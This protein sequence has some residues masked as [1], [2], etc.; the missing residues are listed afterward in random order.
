[1]SVDANGKLLVKDKAKT[2]AWLAEVSIQASDRFLPDFKIGSL[3]MLR[4][5]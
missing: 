2:A 1:L 4:S 3:S 5:H